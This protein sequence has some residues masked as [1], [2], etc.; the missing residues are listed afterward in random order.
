MRY[1]IALTLILFVAVA[2]GQDILKQFPKSFAVSVKNRI[3]RQRD[4][5][6]VVLSPEKLQRI[7]DFNPEAFIVTSK[8]M[9]IPSQYIYLDELNK[10]IAFVVDRLTAN[11]VVEYVIRYN[12]DGKIARE[13]PKHT[14]AELS[15]KTGGEWKDREYLGGNFQNTNYLRVPPQHKDH[16]WFIRYEGPG[17]ESEKVAYRFYLDQR[18]AIDVFGKTTPQPVLQQVGLDGFDSYHEMQPWGMDVMKV[19]TSLGLGS[20]GYLHNGKAIRVEKTDSVSCRIVENGNLFSS[21]LTNYYGWKV[22]DRKVNVASTLSIHKGTRLTHEQLVISATLDKI[23]T[24]IV[25]DKNAVIKLSKGDAKH[26]GYMATYGKQSL[27]N[28]ELGLVVFFNPVDFIE[29]SSDEFSH[30]VTL[31]PKQGRI[32]YY[33]AAAWVKE[34]GGIQDERAFQQYVEDVAQSLAYPVTVDVSAILKK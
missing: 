4:D 11:Q 31:K 24:G 18:N 23:C 21:V 2:H 8:G 19:G 34:P 3:D 17:W 10:G 26:F 16:S 6:L 7:K 14:Q 1:S 30:I 33:F 12:P 29:F 32:D 20:I 5:V 25:K 9:E 15:Y 22:N 28:D 13:Y 27:N